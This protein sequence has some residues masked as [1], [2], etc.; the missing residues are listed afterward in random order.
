M[1]LGWLL[2]GA[3]SALGVVGCASDV[4]DGTVG[5]AEDAVKVDTSS[6]EARAQYDADVA[7]LDGYTPRCQRGDGSR[8]RVLLTGFG[9]FMSITNNATGRLVSE[10]VPAAAYPETAPP[11]PGQVD[12]PGPQLSV[13]TAT[14]HLPSA[15]DVDVC[16]MILPVYW[17]MAAILIAREIDA[18]DP[19][20]VMMNGVAG[21]RQPI[22]LEMGAINRA[23]RSE[24]GSNQLAPW[25]PS[26]PYA[27]II[28]S[29]PDG[30]QPNLLHWETVAAAAQEAI[31]RHADDVDGG[32]RFGDLL[33]GVE[34]GGFPRASNTYLCNNVTY[35][36]GWLMSHPGQTT[37]LLRATPRV[38]GKINEV[39]VK[40]AGDYRNVPRVFVHWPSELDERHH[41][42]GADVMRAILDAELSA[43]AR[44][45]APAPGDNELADADL[46]GA[47]TY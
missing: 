2:V 30:G 7:F 39:R 15:G 41:E 13:A 20:F 28:E 23:Q 22:W 35:V 17:D 3:A 14:I 4:P 11:P 26:A 6:P 36:T 16:A 29:E 33:P 32:A 44:G 8:P 43:L 5:G 9:R 38:R 25:D 40:L 31:E 21:S 12:P 46:K 47:D 24:D 45:E 18:F 37:R 10:I 19:S 42:A 27:K 34:L 1:R